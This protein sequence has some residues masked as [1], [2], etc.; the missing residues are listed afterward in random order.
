VKDLRGRLAAAPAQPRRQLTSSVDVAPLLLTIATGSSSWRRE[1][2]HAHI[3]RRLDLARLLEDPG[4]EGR[5][6]VLHAT[7]EI[8]TEFAV[9]PYAANAPLH[10]VAV[11]TPEA[12]FAAY[13]HWGEEDIAPLSAGEET[14]L[15]DYSTRT[16]RLE[17]HNGAGESAAEGPM[18]A[19]LQHAFR[20][21]LRAPLPAHL[22]AAH[23]RGF[24]D[25]FTTARHAA[26]SAAARRKARE[27]RE[28]G[29][30]EPILGGPDAEGSLRPSS[31]RSPTHR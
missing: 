26:A 2:H 24:A 9:A 20:Q 4:A 10:V 29:S 12:K 25:Y 22:G 28:A 14:E 16:G 8:V 27:E 6:Y 1:P 19:Q 31:S 5:P 13:S 30:T 18:R 11:R 7:D 23:A 3:A 21:E 17:L 15:Y